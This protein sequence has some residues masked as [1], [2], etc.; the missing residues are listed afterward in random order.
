MHDNPE[1]K[2][3]SKEKKG[4]MAWAKKTKPEVPCDNPN[5]AR[6]DPAKDENDYVA[7]EENSR[8]FVDKNCENQPQREV[9]SETRMKEDTEELQTLQQ[10]TINSLEIG[11]KIDA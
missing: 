10:M 9:K 7:I 1:V 5:M 8:I 4:P 11:E 2:E 3:E 6:V